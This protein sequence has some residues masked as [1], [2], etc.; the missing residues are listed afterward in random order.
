MLKDFL[1]DRQMLSITSIC[2]TL[3][4]LASETPTFEENERSVG[5]CG[6]AEWAGRAEWPYQ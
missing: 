4:D 6:A 1:V 3:P 5:H 2:A